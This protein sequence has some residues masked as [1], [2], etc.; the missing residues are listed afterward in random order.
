MLVKLIIVVALG[1]I[2]LF[3]GFHLG[4]KNIKVWLLGIFAFLG[5]ALVF[6]GWYFIYKENIFGL[7]KSS[8]ESRQTYN[9]NLSSNDETP[10]WAVTDFFFKDT[11]DNYFGLSK[12]ALSAAA[13][14]DFSEASA[15]Y[16]KGS[17]YYYYLGEKN[18][19]LN[20][21]VV[22]NNTLPVTLQVEFDENEKL[23]KVQYIIGEYSEMGVFYTFSDSQMQTV[24]VD[25]ISQMQK[26][27]PESNNTGYPV[28]FSDN[29]THAKCAVYA[30]TAEYDGIKNTYS[31][32]NTLYLSLWVA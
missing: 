6:T 30:N 21:S 29:Q 23:Q 13:N 4:K 10:F 27:F 18:S 17:S 26:V 7:V 14:I 20:D 3:L 28:L 15:N 11:A 12:T 22:F 9:Y 31:Y 24:Q 32:G 5:T 2:L 8:T 25:I 19:I 16:V 1:L